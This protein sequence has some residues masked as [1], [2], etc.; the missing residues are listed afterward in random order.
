MYITK[1]PPRAPFAGARW[2]DCTLMLQ[3]IVQPSTTV[4][5][6]ALSSLSSPIPIIPATF[7][8]STRLQ[9]RDQHCVWD[10]VNRFESCPSPWFCECSPLARLSFVTVVILHA[11]KVSPLEILR[12]LQSFGES[13]CCV[14]LGLF[15]HHD[16]LLSRV[17]R[18]GPQESC[19]NM[20]ER[21]ASLS[22][23]DSACCCGV[24]AKSKLDRWP[25]EFQK[26][27]LSSSLQRSTR[28][29]RSRVFG[30]SDLS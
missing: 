1:T 20:L 8:R 29:L 4:A 27:L 7:S 18:L 22:L 21:T 28:F 6:V 12:R 24:E 2:A 9:H 17:F 13:V 23:D 11:E 14:G 5:P 26:L 25:Q 10:C 16:Q 30:N 15:L 3:N 19:L